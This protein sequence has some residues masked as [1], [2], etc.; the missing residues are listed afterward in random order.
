MAIDLQKQSLFLKGARAQTI[1]L[2]ST[3]LKI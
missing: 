1:G 3:Y 2:K